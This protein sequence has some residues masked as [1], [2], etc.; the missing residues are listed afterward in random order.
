MKHKKAIYVLSAIVL[1][2][3][4]ILID[5]YYIYPVHYDLPK[6]ASGYGVYHS[7]KLNNVLYRL[8]K[9]APTNKALIFWDTS[10]KFGMT[11][12]EL[13]ELNPSTSEI[14]FNAKSIHVNIIYDCI[15]EIG[16]SQLKTIHLKIPYEQSIESE[17]MSY[18]G[19][20]YIHSS[21]WKG[22]DESHFYV[23]MLEEGYVVVQKTPSSF[24][25]E[26]L[27]VEL[28]VFDWDWKRNICYGAYLN[29]FDDKYMDSIV[30]KKDS[31][32]ILIEQRKTQ[33]LN[34][35]IF[36]G[37]KFGDSPTIVKR[38][39]Q[40]EK[41]REIQVP[42]GNKVATINIS[43]YDAEYYEN[44]LASLTLYAEEEE[45]SDGLETLYSTK[46][47]KTKNGSWNFA[48][49]SIEIRYVGREVYDPRYEAGYGRSS[50]PTLYHNS[51]RGEYTGYIT[52]DGTF[53][54]IVYSNNHLLRLKDRQKEV[55]D[56]LEKVRELE[57]MEA[58]KELARR[59]ATETATGI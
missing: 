5:R 11:K 17:L 12:S 33:V 24:G 34:S 57:A 27:Y 41:H 35:S 21:R 44:R 55:A 15:Y 48:N 28:G 22:E 45:Y 26:Y 53:L 14:N 42:N 4:Y 43:T 25:K 6:L 59:L 8:K 54:K 9:H 10:V 30:P 20:K 36:A 23:W 38:V 16:D 2:A 56:S 31:I 29:T 7:D 46:Y 51:F 13:I 18:Y 52:K 32:D 47:G 19:T 50:G 3:S 49:C 1:L 39:L 37:L 58:E 40:N